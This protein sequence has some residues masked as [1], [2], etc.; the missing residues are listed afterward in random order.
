ML[1]IEI[2]V[3]LRTDFG[4]KLLGLHFFSESGWDLGI[5]LKLCRH[6]HAKTYY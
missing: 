6:S 5:Y 4:I 2:V 3:K 1:N